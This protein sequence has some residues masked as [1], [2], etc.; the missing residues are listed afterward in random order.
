MLGSLYPDGV[1]VDHIALRRTETTKAAEAKEAAETAGTTTGKKRAASSAPS[2]ITGR[3][4]ARARERLGL[5]KSRFADL[6]GVSAATV[7]NWERKRGKL[8]LHARSL[9]ALTEAAGLTKKEARRRLGE[10]GD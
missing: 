1:T 2:S 10:R 5:S 3:T 7:G 6:L 8:N 9:R 4:V